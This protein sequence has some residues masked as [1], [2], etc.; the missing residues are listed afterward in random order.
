MGNF[1]S[2][3]EAFVHDLKT[4]WYFR[5]YLFVWLL[6][7][8]AAFAGLVT[9]A[10][11]S[12]FNASVS[13]ALIYITNVSEIQFPSFTIQTNQ[14][15]SQ[16]QITNIFCTY[17]LQ[18]GGGTYTIVNSPPCSGTPS[19]TCVTVNASA[20]TA[21]PS[22][23]AIYCSVT[24][25][26]PNSPN[27]DK[28][29]VVTFDGSSSLGGV[30]YVSPNNHAVIL[31]QETIVDVWDDDDDSPAYLWDSDVVYQS[32]VVNGTFFELTIMINSFDV[33]S[34]LDTDGFDAWQSAGAI[35]GF[36]FLMYIVFHI[37]IGIVG[38]VITPDSKFLGIGGATHGGAGT[39]SY[40]N[41]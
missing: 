21:T 1:S 40:A 36:A 24:L 23:N 5:V 37:F 12:A 27:V 17:P 33:I 35:G 7:A 38:C 30:T 2:R 11:R 15:D 28:T 41:L 18:A 9:F 10:A 8:C 39:G 31:L 20:I 34:F 29:L 16:N 22:N 6:L 25:T 13:P 3:M 26:T 19:Q 4:S 32:T 14:G